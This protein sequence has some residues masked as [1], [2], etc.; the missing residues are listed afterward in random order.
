MNTL[1]TPLGVQATFQKILQSSGITTPTPVQQEAI[2]VIMAG[3]DVVVQ[4][5]TGTGK[6]LAFVL[7]I[8]EKVNVEQTHI[9]A[10]IITPTRELA[11][12]ITAEVKKL[13][14]AIG[15]EVLAAYG[16]QDVEGQI[17]KLK[18]EPQ[19]VV[20]TPGRLLDHLR[21][22]TL[23]LTTLSMLV[24][25]EADEMLDMGFWGEME[26]VIRQTPQSRQTMLFSA[27]M[28]DSVKKLA[29]QVMKNP[30][31]IVINSNQITV[32]DIKQY[33]VEVSDRAKQHT[34]I[35]MIQ[36]FH[37]YL[38]LVFCRTKIRAKKLTTAL[39]ASGIK[40]DELHGDLSQAKREN[41]MK[42]FR[43]AKL[44][45]LV[46]TDV[47]ARGL[48][49][50][51]ITHVFNYDIPQDAD[52]YVH[53]IGR[54]GRAGQTGLAFT[55]VAPRDQNTLA[56]IERRIKVHIPRRQAD[57]FFDD[58]PN[59]HHSDESKQQDHTRHRSPKTG[60]WGERKRSDNKR[61][62]SFRNDQRGQGGSGGRSGRG[63][64]KS[65]NHTSK[66]RRGGGQTPRSHA[67]SS[68]P[69]GA[70]RGRKRGRR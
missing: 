39:I 22:E 51:G 11:I 38:A 24:I 37:P 25:D 43:D 13:A 49:V 62:R 15:A 9:Q 26:E 66:N 61:K 40:A 34:L 33:A 36:T 4:A 44:Q 2:P 28:P 19:I 52:N 14:E 23:K 16:G 47:A 65:S 12:Q 60:R 70:N 41:V 32:E 67:S 69:Y 68:K 17:R 64:S 3:K 48:D 58:G 59:H 31:D 5:Q 10:L 29:N 45:V 8:V 1:F 50:E 6:T 42:R 30:T 54:T 53:R 57:S 56:Q 7:P 35:H 46:A 21:R 27:T 55:F 20:A 18:N 63:K